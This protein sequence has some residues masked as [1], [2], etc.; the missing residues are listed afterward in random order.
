MANSEHD[1]ATIRQLRS[2]EVEFLREMLY[3]A[4][5]WRS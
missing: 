4:L 1:T 2:D 5:D 3:A